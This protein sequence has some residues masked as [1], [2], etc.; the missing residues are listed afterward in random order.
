MK[1]DRKEYVPCD[2]CLKKAQ[3]QAGLIDD[4]ESFEGAGLCGG[5][6]G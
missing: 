4:A 1:P 6:R 2:C 3:K 5:G